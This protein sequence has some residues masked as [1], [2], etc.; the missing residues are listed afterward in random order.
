MKK[1]QLIN[2]LDPTV[3]AALGAR[4]FDVFSSVIMADYFPDPPSE[5]HTYLTDTISTDQ[6]TGRREVVV[7]PR[8]WGKSTTI[9]EGGTAWI[10]CRNLF[11]PTDKQYKYIV[12]V[13]ASE[14][15]SCQRLNTIK[16][17]LLSP[18]VE[19]YYPHAY[20]Q[21]KV[22]RENM[23]VTKNGVCIEAKGITSAGRGAKYEAR[24]PDAIIADDV[25]TLDTAMSATLSEELMS[26]FILDV[27]KLGHRDTDIIV[28]GTILSKRCL[29]Y[30]LL[31]DDEYATWNGRLFRALEKFPERMDLWDSWGAIL[32]NRKLRH[33]KAQA[34]LF[35][36]ENK[37]EM[38]KGG[39]SNW[40]EARPVIDLMGEYYTLGRSAFMSE[41]QNSLVDTDNT[42]FRP[43][44]YVYISKEEFENY[45]EMNPIIYT[46]VD[47]TVG[48]KKRARFTSRGS[49][50][51][52]I[53]LVGKLSNDMY[54][55][56][57]SF[58]KQCRQS[59]QYDII[60][61]FLQKYNVFR[62]I[63]E[64]NGGQMHYI[65]GLEKAIMEKYADRNWVQTA[66]T[67]Y[68]VR[69]RGAH[70]SINKH[71]R[72]QMLEPY[73]DNH[74]LHLR[75]NMQTTHPVLWDSLSTYPACEYLDA[76]DG[77]AGAFFSAYK[78]FRLTYL[79]DTAS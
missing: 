8:G 77:L 7:G 33:R 79:Y 67:R 51:F 45:M 6:L 27:C 20:G 18:L 3:V 66:K 59:D 65:N 19:K 1:E 21:G 10:V 13:S 53:S 5:F 24:R 74:T 14:N 68:P 76:L 23:I 73:L 55:L 17:V 70:N 25:D 28:V 34:D 72:I 49:D 48:L 29:A 16:S 9:T 78:T 38:D 43:A 46:F 62:L 63:V 30:R 22:W 57:D 54:F 71:E 56:V 61:S 37:K 15:Q 2:T 12:I 60:I 32:K 44:Q 41:C 40:P 36:Q 69:P 47:P 50:M 42:H 75:E 31:Y 26:R 39:V 35:Y 11:L 52:N 58:S 64:S 4:S